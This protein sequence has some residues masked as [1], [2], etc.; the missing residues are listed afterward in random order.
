[1][2]V[3]K[4]D[5]IKVGDEVRFKTNSPH[6]N[7]V[8]SGT[9]IGI[10][11]YAVARNFYDVDSYYADIKKHN[12]SVKSKEAAEY[13]LLQVP[14]SDNSTTNVAFAKDWIDA[15]TLEHIST[16]D[17]IDIRIY[18]ISK[19]KATDILRYIQSSYVGYVAEILE[20]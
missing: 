10:C 4:V 14:T 8:W 16:G 20:N 7:V 13:L 1:M 5:E 15:S 17:Y 18:N 6:D 12:S 19:D 9:V 2:T 3:Q 11:G